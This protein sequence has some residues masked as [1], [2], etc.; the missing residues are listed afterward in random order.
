MPGEFR[1][2][3]LASGSSGNSLYAET[4]DGAI[5]VDAGLS[6]KQLA[7]K[8]GEIGGDVER[9]DAILISHD[10]SDHARG[11]GVLSRRFGIPLLMTAGTFH[12]CKHNLGKVVGPRLF[13]PGQTLCVGGFHVH[14]LETPHDGR[15][16]VAF[17]LERDGTRCG[18]LT[19]LGCVF[20]G[21]Q[22][23]VPTLDAVV[24]ESNYCPK[25]LATGPYPPAL[26]ERIRSDH[27][28]ISNSE[29]ARLVLEHAG[30]RLSLILLAHLSENNNSPEHALEIWRRECGARLDGQQ[31]QL[32]V[33]PRHNPSPTIVV[34][35]RG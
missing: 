32:L 35:R 20:Q 11:A 15:E 16:G 33:A 22:E 25:M 4:A 21:L 7:A 31:V 9:L 1:I 14:T 29:A 10:H 12:G 17:I 23:T 19:D 28:H 5:L 18:V 34:K 13:T 8:I 6:A 30:E 3:T 24:I 2:T 26:Q 27:G